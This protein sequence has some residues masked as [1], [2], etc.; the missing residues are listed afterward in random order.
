MTLTDVEL[1]KMIEDGSKAAVD[2]ALAEKAVADKAKE[3]EHKTAL[4]A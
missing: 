3:D 2:A 1:K 4:R